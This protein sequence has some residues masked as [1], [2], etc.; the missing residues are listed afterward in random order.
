MKKNL[1]KKA[2]IFFALIISLISVASLLFE[3]Q[4]P[5]EQSTGLINEWMSVNK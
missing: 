2:I 1:K 3:I 4:L 5:K